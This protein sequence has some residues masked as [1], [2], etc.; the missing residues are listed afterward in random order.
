MYSH[1][2]VESA[3]GQFAGRFKHKTVKR[4][5]KELAKA[6]THDSMSAFSKLTHDVNSKVE[7]FDESPLTPRRDA[8]P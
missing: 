8:V 6:R 5:E 3:V 7:I 2:D 4:T 1:L